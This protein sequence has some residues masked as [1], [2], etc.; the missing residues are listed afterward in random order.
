[1]LRHV[2]LKLPIFI[3]VSEQEDPKN[4]LVVIERVCR[5]LN[6]S[7]VQSF[8]FTSYQL[9]DVAN[10]WFEIWRSL[11]EDGSSSPTREKF[12]EVFLELFYPSV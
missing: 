8:E 6:Y 1:M 11:R 4:F 3:G 5:A 7:R 10:A 12:Q 2:K 9:E